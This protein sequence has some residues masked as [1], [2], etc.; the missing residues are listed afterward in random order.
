MFKLGKKGVEE[1]V[2]RVTLFLNKYTEEGCAE[3]FTV[4]LTVVFA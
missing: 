3:L 1:R 2:M 4:A